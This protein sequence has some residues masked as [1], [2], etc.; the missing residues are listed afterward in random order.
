MIMVSWYPF[1]TPLCGVVIIGFLSGLMGTFSFLQKNTMLGDVVAHAALPGIVG[2]FIL[3]H[4]NNLAVLLTG[5]F[6][7][8]LCAVMLITLVSRFTSLP[9]DALFG[10]VLSVFFG[11]GLLL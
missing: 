10:T 6:C 9:I 1:C 8:G 3:T 5:G 7:A 11:A 4:S 2:A